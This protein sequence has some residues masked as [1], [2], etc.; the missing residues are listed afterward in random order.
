MGNGEAASPGSLPLGSP[1]QVEVLDRAVHF[2]PVLPGAARRSPAS[3]TFPLP[4]PADAAAPADAQLQPGRPGSADP[5][6]AAPQTA[7]IALA[8]K[9]AA[10]APKA[11][12]A[13]K[14]DPEPRSGDAAPHAAATGIDGPG[15]PAARENDRPRSGT[16]GIL[17]ASPGHR[18]PPSGSVQGAGNGSGSVPGQPAAA[19]PAIAAAIKEEI[20]RA[21]AAGPEGRVSADPAIPT[22][23]DGPL[24]VLKIQ[25]RP[26]NL[27]IVTVELR[28]TDGQLETHLRASRPETAAM[29]QRDS[30]ILAELLKQAHYRPE[31]TVGSVRPTDA[32]SSAG[33]SPS[34]GQPAF[35]DGGARPGHGGDGQRQREQQRAEQRPA[36]GR[37][38]GER[39]DET[40]R[41]RDGGVYL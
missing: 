22:A 3:A 13:L 34:Q 29:L 14:T 28:L 35:T 37:R 9:V 18:G 11:T 26:E 2:K 12:V 10:A 16:A 30:A 19:L 6:A 5:A 20:E 25:L 33:G 17:L 7:R 4:A 39:T 31:I 23:P 32:G 8:D 24:R 15:D 27:G 41:P 1:P 36:I 21:A 40:V 38:D